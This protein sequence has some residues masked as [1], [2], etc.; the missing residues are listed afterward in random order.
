MLI[1]EGSP[2]L[3]RHLATPARCYHTVPPKALP[4]HGQINSAGPSP[5]LARHARLCYIS[6]PSQKE[7]KNQALACISLQLTE[8]N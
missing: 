1:D 5:P 3:Y 4:E 6:I 7:N 8:K 2:G